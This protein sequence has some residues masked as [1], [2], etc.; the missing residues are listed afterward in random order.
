[1]AKYDV[2]IVGAG[3]SGLVASFYLARAGWKVLILERGDQV[4]G[5]CVTEEIFPGYHGSSVANSSH[6]LDPQI[7]AD[8]E[9]H[10]FGLQLTHPSL[11][12]ITFFSN[13]D[14]LVM[15]PDREQR[16][17]E[18]LRFAD[19]DDLQGFSGVL[20]FYERIAKKMGVSFYEPPPAFEDVAARFSEPEDKE[21]FNLVMFGSVADVLDRHLKSPWLQAFMAGTAMATNLIGPRTPGSAYLL[22]QRP[23]YEE[24]MRRRGIE[25]NN[26]LMM[27]NASPIGGVG[28]VT[29]AMARSAQAMG[30]EIMLEAEV[31]EILC[32]KGRALGVLLSGGR[33]F[34][35]RRVLANVN[36]KTVLT[37]M[38]T[39]NQLPKDVEDRARR[40][41]MSG[42]SSKVH[43][44]L[45]G[46]PRFRRA[47]NDAEN[48]AFLKTNFRVVPSVDVLQESYNEAIMGSWSP[49]VTVSGVVSSA[50][51]PSMTPPGCHFM[52]LSVRG[53]PYHLAN[54][55]DWETERDALGKAVVATL[56]N[57]ITNLDSI[58]AG[59]HVYT[60]VDL[61]KRFGMVE[62]NGAHGDIIPGKIFDARPLPECSHYATPI[63]GLYMC[64]TGMWPANYMSGLT[65]YNASH[66]MLA[67]AHADSLIRS[68]TA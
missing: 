61:E 17:R 55:R 65:G 35:A 41:K 16:R 3:H 5:T 11:S 40:M 29:K 30:V 36:P 27:K 26:E 20:R 63:E 56:A 24:S 47:R 38:V 54:G 34:E 59:V 18:M 7:S 51:D 33:E 15:W 6:S 62:G 48:E 1:M 37:R 43:L 45:E 10:K 14:A 4:G 25:D 67:D 64:G 53:T 58:L 9:L 32:D 12:S 21:A 68:A 52:S 60:P 42:S 28:A 39:S 8:M 50:V 49:K 23:L 22:L 57:N 31:A 44:A 46:T 66:R 13:G 19:E 2:V